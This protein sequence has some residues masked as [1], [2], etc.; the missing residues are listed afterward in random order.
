MKN[1]NIIYT[2]SK[3]VKCDGLKQE[4]GH[5]LVYLNIKKDKIVCPYCSL[6]FVYKESKNNSK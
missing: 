6:E 2:E 4:L 3:K 5:P 1:K